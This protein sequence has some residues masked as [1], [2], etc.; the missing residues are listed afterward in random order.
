MD[1][2][3]GF[4]IGLLGSFHCV[5]MCGP[6]T[7]A[8]PGGYAQKRA[9]IFGR[10]LY[11]LGR[12]VTYSLLG[13]I[14]G[15]IGQSIALAGYQQSLSIAL[16]VVILL[17]VFLPSKYAAKLLPF[18]PVQTFMVR[19]RDFW[20]RL[21]RNNSHPS[22]FTIGV[23]NGFLPC[24]FVYVGLAGAMSTG[25][26]WSGA[27]YM[28]LFG[29][30]TFPIM[31]ATSLAG[32]WVGIEVRRF[33]QKLVPVGAVLLAVLF[34]LRGLSL[35][36]PYISPKMSGKTPAQMKLQ[37]EKMQHNS[38]NGKMMMETDGSCCTGE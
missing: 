23:L 2:W 8:L 29:M 38:G 26:V 12:I 32:N 6:I 17:G 20:G 35:G 27:A 9:W 11:N 22:L 7:L 37:M 10:V 30:G 31:L 3:T 19:V 1:I 14:F 18:S 36:I 25:G 13:I 15:I 33:I 28:A 24:G 34:I 5:G 21:F 16:G 4:I